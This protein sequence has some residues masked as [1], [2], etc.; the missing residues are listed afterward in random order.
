[1]KKMTLLATLLLALVEFGHGQNNQ[2]SVF[3]PDR[4]F[5]LEG[6]IKNYHPTDST[7]FVTLRTTS[8]KGASHDTAVYINERGYFKCHLYQPFDGDI[9]FAYRDEFIQLYA[10][11]DEEIQLELDDRTWKTEPNKVKVLHVMGKSAALSKHIIDFQHQKAIHEFNVNPDFSNKEQGDERFATDCIIRMNEELAF[12]VKY[13]E[14]NKIDDTRFEKW[15]ASD[16]TYRTGKSIAFYCFTGKIN[17]T[18]TYPRLMKY[19]NPIPLTNPDALSSTSYYKFLDFIVGDFGI[20]SNVNALYTDSIRFHGNSKVAF[21]LTQIDSYSSGIT[22]QLMYYLLYEKENKDCRVNAGRFASTITDPYLRQLF[23]REASPKE[24][25]LVPANVLAKI[26]RQPGGSSLYAW[27]ET[28]LKKNKGSFVFLDFWGSWCG[29]CMREMPLY[30]Q[31]IN[32]LRGEPIVFLFLAVDTKEEKMN[33]I[34]R[35][36]GVNAE[37]ILLTDNDVKIFN[38]VLQFSSYPSHFILD[39]A[40][41]VVDRGASVLNSG[42]PEAVKQVKSVIAK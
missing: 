11:H 40:G 18:I 37:F 2:N 23:I 36:Y 41:S 35:N 21:N 33:E 16:I 31:L 39:P 6:N 25:V 24:E 28:F 19:L 34:K 32:D 12:L 1:M 42:I 30:P 20:I 38:N 27:M 7:G 17:R 4:K 3:N 14:E 26:K 22:R 29:P 10:A 9:A 8:V 15:C 5:T 13:I